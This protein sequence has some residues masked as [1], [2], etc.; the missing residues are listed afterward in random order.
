M[1]LIRNITGTQTF[2]DGLVVV[3]DVNKV[4]AAYINELRKK[5]QE[6]VDDLDE[7]IGNYGVEHHRVV[8]YD[9]AGFMSVH[10]KVIFDEHTHDH[11]GPD[12]LAHA[13]ASHERNGFQSIQDKILW[14]NHRGFGGDAEHPLVTDTLSGFMSPDQK[15]KLQTI[16][17]TYVTKEYFEAN[18]FKVYLVTRESPKMGLGSDGGTGW[19]MFNIDRRPLEAAVGRPLMPYPAIY[20][21]SYAVRSIL[22]NWGSPFPVYGADAKVA[23]DPNFFSVG[24]NLGYAGTY[25]RSGT[26]QFAITVPLVPTNSIVSI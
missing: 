25:H 10:D 7:H 3:A 16:W 11:M 26:L 24:L 15:G 2:E 21:P 13:V 14:D 23:S 8:D 20:H 19:F 5:T 9:K 18:N 17:D 12:G 4:R 6:I 22:Y 1:A